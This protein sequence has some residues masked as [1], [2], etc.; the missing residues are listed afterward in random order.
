MPPAYKLWIIQRESGLCLVDATLEEVPSGTK[1]DGVLISGLL[2][3]L[4]YLSDTLVGEEMR[5]FETKSYR[6]LMHTEESLFFAIL[7][8][9]KTPMRIAEHILQK[10][11]RRFVKNSRELIEKSKSGD[12]TDFAQVTAQIEEITQFKGIKLA[13]KI[14]QM[15]PNAQRF[16]HEVIIENLKKN[17]QSKKS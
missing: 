5:F 16:S 8:S 10:M 4:M 15:K 3:S 9:V 7:T 2:T 1:I 6:I 13:R 17:F 12:V 14:R 11:S